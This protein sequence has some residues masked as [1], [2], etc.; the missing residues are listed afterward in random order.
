MNDDDDDDDD[1]D[2]VQ[3]L[4]INQVFKGYLLIANGR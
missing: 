2:K 3:V 1:D 4:L